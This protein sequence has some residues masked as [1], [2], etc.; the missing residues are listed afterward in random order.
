[1]V[2][3]ICISLM[4]SDVKHLFM[5][6]LAIYMSSLGKCLVRSYAHFLVRLFLFVLLLSCMSSL[7][8]MLVPY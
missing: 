4:N 6:L 2:V 1:M 8:W 7:F 3:L 5:Y